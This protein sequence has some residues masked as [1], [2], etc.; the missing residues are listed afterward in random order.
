MQGDSSFSSKA[1]VGTPLG[2]PVLV[3]RESGTH[4]CLPATVGLRE[5]MAAE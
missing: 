3:S 1:A 5:V 2:A 4:D